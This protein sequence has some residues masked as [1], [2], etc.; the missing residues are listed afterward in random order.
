[1]VVMVEL[2]KVTC[3]SGCVFAIS[4]DLYDYMQQKGQGHGDIYCPLGHRF[5]YLNESEAQKIERLQ[6]EIQRKDNELARE[7]EEKERLKRRALRGLC[8]FCKRT[9]L[10]VQ[11][12]MAC[13][14]KVI[15]VNGTKLLEAKR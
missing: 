9:F 10:N 15:D 5:H 3:C 11:R 13:K 4:K 7:R 2:V 6:L 8:I 14:H 12:H 1:M